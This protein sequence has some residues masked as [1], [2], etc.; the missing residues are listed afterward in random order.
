[1]RGGSPVSALHI[2]VRCVSCLQGATSGDTPTY[3][4]NSPEAG[5][6]TDNLGIAD[7][8]KQYRVMFVA[9]RL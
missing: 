5:R 7:A 9:S 4:F 1:M 2:P 3:V 6:Q 8:V